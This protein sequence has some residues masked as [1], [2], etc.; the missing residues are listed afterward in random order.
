LEPFKDKLLRPVTDED[1]EML[2]GV[3]IRRISLFDIDKHRKE[4]EGILKELVQI[5]K[6]LKQL[7]PY[8]IKYLQDLLKTYGKVYPRRT[9]ITTFG[10]IAV[11]EL[12]ATELKIGYD[13]ERGYIGHGVNGE[14][15]FA[16][17]SYDRIAVFSQDGRY[18]VMAPPE[19]FS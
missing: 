6:Y 15:L 7:R 3:R 12:T 4:I 17:S 9:E 8:V 18:W 1:I 5:E 11:R 19:R 10:S 2:L 13:A 16:C 14:T